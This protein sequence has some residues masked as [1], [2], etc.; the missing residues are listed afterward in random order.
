MISCNLY[1]ARVVERHLFDNLARTKKA[2]FLLLACSQNEKRKR[3]HRFWVR[4]VFNNR[5][6]HHNVFIGLRM[7]YRCIV[8]RFR[9][10]NRW[11][12]FPYNRWRSLTL[13][14]D[15]DHME[16]RLK[17]DWVQII[18]SLQINPS[19]TVNK[20]IVCA[21]SQTECL[22]FSCISSC[23]NIKRLQRTQSCFLV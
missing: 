2:A 13:A 4:H 23:F 12:V 9:S 3:T 19:Q 10:L 17:N 8:G 22:C 7:F 6:R 15:R 18:I 14:D 21:N 20:P 16:T 1:D 11:N 5:Q